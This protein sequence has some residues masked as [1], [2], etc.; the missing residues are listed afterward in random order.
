MDVRIDESRHH[1]GFA[2]FVHGPSARN[3]IERGNTR[4]QPLPDVNR[5]AP[6]ASGRNYAAATNDEVHVVWGA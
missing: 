5:R 2:G 4:D 6:L 1:D 3:I